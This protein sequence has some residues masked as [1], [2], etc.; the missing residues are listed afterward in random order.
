MKLTTTKPSQATQDTINALRL[1]GI[2]F[3]IVTPVGFRWEL[4]NVVKN[5]LTGKE[6]V[7]FVAE[8]DSYGNIVEAGP[9]LCNGIPLRESN[10][11]LNADGEQV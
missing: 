10:V 9:I 4:H 8:L 5:E 7:D 6:H 2:Q 1:S 3:N 11:V